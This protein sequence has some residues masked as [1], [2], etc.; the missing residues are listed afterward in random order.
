[1]PLR[2]A[3]ALNRFRLEIKLDQHG[4]L[5]PHHPAIMTRLDRYG[6]RRGELLDAPVGILDMNL[7]LGEEA[8][9][10]VHAAVRLGDGLHVRRPTKARLINDPLDARI[11][12]SNGIDAN[13]ADLSA[14]RAF[15][16]TKQ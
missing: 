13:A 2:H 5:I 15:D 11:T 9:M 3:E 1:M 12:G 4:W 14:L 7:P 10:R 16:W 6:R 8:N